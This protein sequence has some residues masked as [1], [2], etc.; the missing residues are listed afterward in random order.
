MLEGS[1]SVAP[2]GMVRFKFVGAN[3]NNNL[4]LGEGYVTVEAEDGTVIANDSSESTLIIF[5]NKLTN[6]TTTVEWDTTDVKPGNYTV[7]LKGDSRALDG[8]VTP[9]EGVAKVAVA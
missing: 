5:D 4:H 8:K 9:F 2:G 7:R 6:T 1:E 3:P